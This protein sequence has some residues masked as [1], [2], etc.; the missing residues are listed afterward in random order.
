LPEW[1]SIQFTDH[2]NGGFFERV[3][4]VVK[5]PASAHC[6]S[7]DRGIKRQSASSS[8]SQTPECT[9]ASGRIG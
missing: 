7:Q 8:P 5:G 3:H 2:L 6:R 4:S 9:R 1:D